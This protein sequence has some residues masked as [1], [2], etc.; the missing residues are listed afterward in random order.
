VHSSSWC[1]L[2]APTAELLRDA[3]FASSSNFAECRTE[4]SA[5]AK[6]ERSCHDTLRSEGVTGTCGFGLPAALPTASQPKGKFSAAESQ[7]Q[8]FLH[9]A[10]KA[11]S[12][13]VN[14]PASLMAIV[15]LAEKSTFDTVACSGD[16]PQALATDVFRS[17][18]CPIPERPKFVRLRISRQVFASVFPCQMCR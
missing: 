8:C 14:K 2:A 10:P 6:C 9:S 4:K 11:S 5:C 15:R 16:Y 3:P 17:H 18:V 12:A 1:S 7:D 13:R